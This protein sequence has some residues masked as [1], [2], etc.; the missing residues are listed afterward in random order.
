MSDNVAVTPGAGASIATDDCGASGQVQRVRVAL[1]G[2]GVMDD[3]IVTSVAINCAASGDNTIVALGASQ[4]IRV[5]GF[6]LV[7][8][9]SV[10]VKWRDGTAGTDFHP[11]IQVG[12]WVL[13]RDRLPW[14]VTTAS[15]ALVLNLSA[16]IQVSG[17]LYYAKS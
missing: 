11:A 17:R 9:S 7:A 13:D 4:T 8:A 10:S 3:E 6:F 5:Y 2:P 15:L 1:G 16:A 14:F 12:S